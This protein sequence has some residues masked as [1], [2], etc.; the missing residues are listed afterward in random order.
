MAGDAAPIVAHSTGAAPLPLAGRT[1][2]FS[3]AG[4]LIAL[5]YIVGYVALDWISYLY[6]LAPFAI[7]PWNPP[8]GLSIALLTI[9]GLRLWPAVFI[10]VLAAELLVRPAS[11]LPVAGVTTALSFA[12]GYCAASALLHFVR[13]DAALTRVRDVVWLVVIAVNGSVIIAATYVGLLVLLQALN[14]ADALDAILRLWVGDAIGIL[15]TAPL[16]MLLFARTPRPTETVRWPL[17]ELALQALAVIAALV[18][19]F[20]VGAGNEERYFYLLFI[21]LIWVCLRHGLPGAVW[22]LVAIQIGLLVGFRFVQ[23]PPHSV[24]ELQLLMLAIAITGL[25]LGAAVSERREA[26]AALG[27]REAELRTVVATAPDAILAIDAQGVV[28][29]ANAAAQAMFGQ[30]AQ[31]IV[32]AP[33]A[34][35]V[36]GAPADLDEVHNAAVTGVRA[37][38]ATFPAE[39]SFNRTV[40]S[41]RTMRIGVVRDISDRTRMEEQ[42]RERERQLDRTMRLASA[43]EL[44]SAL[45]HELNQPLAA[46]A[47]YVRACKLLIE[48]RQDADPRLQSTMGRAIEE[49]ARAGDVLRRLREYFRTGGARLEWVDLNALIAHVAHHWSDRTNASATEL[50]LRVEPTLA[51][52]FA[53]RVQLEIVL[54]NLVGNALDSLLAGAAGERQIEIGAATEG[55]AQ[56]HV[57]VRD[58]GPGLTEAVLATLFQPFATSKPAGMGL[59]LA[60]SRSIVENHGG[61]LWAEPLARGAAFHFT[62]PV[63]TPQEHLAEDAS[64]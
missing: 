11:G 25:M 51:Q 10:A 59:G 42:L 12:F 54:H 29:S 19:V 6:P 44:A 40:T 8:P 36:I 47:N 17:A 61:R 2:L 27:S 34:R 35:F 37:D 60:L 18:G 56:V 28:T 46:V 62:L 38:G 15:V 33:L 26:L 39:A 30:S 57:T 22:C 64:A 49:V 21:P 24:L 20:A 32:G 53:D 13:F 9:A 16:V 55:T 58:S 14:P 23:H 45:A 63:G 41:D 3:G 7:T 43:S 5:A 4:V 31:R 1:S 50:T 48:S 52:V